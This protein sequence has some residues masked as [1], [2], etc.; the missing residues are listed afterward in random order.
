MSPFANRVHRRGR[1]ERGAALAMTGI[2]M[3]LIVGMAV[4]GVDV[5]HLAFTANEVQALADLSATSYM[6]SVALNQD[7]GG[8]RN[9]VTETESVI[10]AN[11]VGGGQAT[12]GNIERFE[13]GAYDV[14]TRTFTPG[15]TPVNAVRATAVATVP[16]FFAGIYGDFETTVRREAIASLTP[17]GRAPVLP[18]AIGECFWDIF[19]NTGDC[20]DQPRFSQIPSND[21]N[22]CWTSLLEGSANANTFRNLIRAYC[23]LNGEDP[24]TV[25]L[26][27][28]IALN[29]G[30][31]TGPALG[32]IQE[33]LDAGI[34]EFVV[35][36]IPCNRQC[37]QTAEVIGFA[38]I[39]V[40]SVVKSGGQ[41]KMGVN[42]SAVCSTD[43]PGAAGG[44]TEPTGTTV[45][46]LVQ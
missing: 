23:R 45:V 46:S 1:G 7:D 21:D 37:N 25:T 20:S 26:H 30:Q 13:P 34:N 28:V 44:G 33:C 10:G 32:A 19:E 43:P 27:D 12:L 18:L 17:P 36:V 5:G 39:T 31:V 16:N 14:A 40:T 42:A 38:T 8:S 4:V 24:G 35:P 3:L 11:A 22:S 6:K 29:E 9:P 2:A 15:A 41:A